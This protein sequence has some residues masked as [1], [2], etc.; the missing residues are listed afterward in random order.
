MFNRTRSRLV[1]L[2]A[3]VFFILLN[4]F[5]AMNY[6]Y[7]Q[8]RLYRT[9]NA[10]LEDITKDINS[11]Q[12]EDVG[13]LI[14]PEKAEN[15]R[16]I[17]LLWQK[18]GKLGHVVPEKGMNPSDAQQFGKLRNK[19][20]IQSI[21]IKSR[22]YHFVNIQVK[23]DKK[24]PALQTIQIIYN[25][26]REKEMLQHLLIVIGFGDVFSIFMAV[27]AGL[28]LANKAFIPI[29]KSWDRQQQFVADAS[30]ELRTP[31]SV[32]KLNL[33]HLFRHPNRT[34]EQE[35]EII[36]QVIQE[37]NYMTRMTKDL[38]TLARSDA[39]QLDMVKSPIRLDHIINQVV[40]DFKALAQLK[41]I[42]LK[43]D[44]KGPIEMFG[45]PER[46][47][48]CLVILLDNALKY[49]KNSGKIEVI[50]NMKNGKA[51][52]DIIDTGVGIPEADLPYIFDRYYRGDKSRTRQF[53][54]TGLGLS[55]AKWIIQSHGG[56][57]RVTSKV[58]KGTDVQMS[59][60]LKMKG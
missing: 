48:Q 52:L 3:L 19:K 55:I 41:D 47:K 15:N 32:M 10:S 6:F 18:N 16:V 58:G 11:D 44:I 25:L 34:I 31:L 28:Y 22:S 40:K 59:F 26:G 20:K 57:I 21:T 2:N 49:T 7:T 36:S 14:S 9:A 27:V 24:Y 38:L 1:V 17:Y 42:D 12:S 33:E 53:E 56:K 5:G 45:D 35:S 43:S 8:Y 39:D 30:H 60:P 46:L 50:A 29:K 13:K 51:I 4:L 37:I 23:H 54:G